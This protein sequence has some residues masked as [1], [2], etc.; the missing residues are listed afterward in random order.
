MWLQP[1]LEKPDVVH[2]FSVA[3][4]GAQGIEQGIDTQ[5]AKGA[6]V[7]LIGGVEPFEGMVLVAQIPIQLRDQIRRH[8]SVLGFVL[9]KGDFDLFAQ[10][11]WP[12]AR[13]EARFQC[14]CEI[15][16]ILVA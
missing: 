8:V 15:S 7:F 1:L 9:G 4:V 6:V 3:L 16:H 2:Q 11:S 13:A 14:R 5:L 10:G 12:S